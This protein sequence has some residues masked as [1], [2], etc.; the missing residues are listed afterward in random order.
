MKQ[1]AVQMG[2]RKKKTRVQVFA[3]LKEALEEALKY[4]TVGPVVLKVHKRRKRARNSG[5]SL[6]LLP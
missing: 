2:K 6:G 1:L 5:R 3:S 4:E